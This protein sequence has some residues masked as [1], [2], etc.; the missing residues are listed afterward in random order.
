[1]ALIKKHSV[2]SEEVRKV[3]EDLYELVKKEHGYYE[4]WSTVLVTSDD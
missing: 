3:V 1:M 4:G 2:V